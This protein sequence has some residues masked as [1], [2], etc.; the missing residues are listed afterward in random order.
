MIKEAT[1]LAEI[2]YHTK[3]NQLTDDTLFIGFTTKQRLEKLKEKE[4]CHLQSKRSFFDGVRQ[5]YEAATK[6]IF[7]KF[8][9]NDDTLN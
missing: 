3:E 6:Y 4:K 5:Y 7:D 1:H 8:P 9:L 2:D